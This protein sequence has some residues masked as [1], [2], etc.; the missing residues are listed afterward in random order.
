MNC[1]KLLLSLLIFCTATIHAAERPNVLMLAIDDLNDWIGCL[2]GHPQ[3]I[4]PNLDRLAARGVLFTNAHCQSPVCN[5]SRASL[6]SSTYPETSGIYFLTPE[7]ADSTVIASQKTIPER[8]EAESYEVSAVGKLFHG[9]QNKTYFKDYGGN[10]GGAGPRRKEKMS[11]PFGHPLWDW[12]AIPEGNEYMPDTKV[13]DWGVEKLKTLGG[14]PFFLGVGFS[15]PHV[16]LYAPQEWFDMYPL[17]KIQLPKV[18]ENDLD[19][20]S[21]YGINITRLEHIAPTQKWMVEHNEWAH[22]VQSYLACVS[23]VDSRVGMMLDAL[24]NHPAKDNTIIVLFSDHGWHLGEKERW[25]K[26]SLWEDSTRVPMMIIAPGM[27]G[28]QV[29]NKPVQLLDIYPTLL[30]LT[31][32]KADPANEGHSLRPLLENAKAD[33]PHMA[34]CAWGPG[35]VAICSERYRYI[36]YNDGSEEFYDHRDD[37]NEWTNLAG[38]PE[39]RDL[40][41][42][43]ATHL[44]KTYAKILGEGSYGHLSYAATEAARKK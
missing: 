34:R 40:M 9:R 22:A 20:L 13:A 44:P 2:G 1:K 6:M 8:F 7:P 35:N 29:C 12:G 28:G 26:R 3:A 42:T 18:Q 39:Y 15:R 37:P 10:M 31:G 19:D 23:F 5:P 33:W 25:A 30:E 16:P 14:R 24:D 38:N 41:K 21:E 43:H 32:L 11:M 4:T 36:H 27:K 17:D